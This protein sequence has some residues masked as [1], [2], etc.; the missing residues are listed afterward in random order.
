M[1]HTVK[2]LILNAG[3][4][5]LKAAVFTDPGGPTG[6]PSDPGWSSTEAAAG[7]RHGDAAARILDRTVDDVDVVAHRIVHGGTEI[8]E[9][10]VV[11]SEVRAALDDAAP[12][13]PIHGPAALAVLDAAKRAIPD[14]QHVAVPDTGFHRT[15]PAQAAAYAGPYQWFETGLRRIGFHGLAH[16]YAAHRAAFVLGRPAETLGVVSC[17]LGG[18]C[19]VAA[20]DRGRSVDTTMGFTP[21]DGL[22]MA[23][24]SGAVDP[25][26]LI[27]L[28]RTGTNV[29]ELDDTINHRSGLLGLSGRSADF[30]EVLEHAATGDDRCKLA[31]DVYLHRLRTATGAMAAALDGLDAIVVSGGVGE[32]CV[33]VHDELRRL[34]ATLRDEPP[35][36]IEAAREDWVLALAATAAVE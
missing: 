9:P 18:G 23:T 19:S 33:A 30:T 24:R 34:S 8:I 14:A 2:V 35:V 20:V 26:L 36:L 22:A 16:E 29:D 7:G 3:S 32:R 28:L 15:M 25:G 21:V 4:G 13:A 11:T 5:T 27:H 17:H 31:I 1:A 6:E 12:L 10:T